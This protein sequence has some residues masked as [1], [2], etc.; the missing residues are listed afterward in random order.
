MAQG[1]DDL[2]GHSRLAGGAATANADDERLHLLAGNVV[3]R[4][5]ARRVERL[6]LSAQ[7]K[8]LHVVVEIHQKMIIKQ[9]SFID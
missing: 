4:R 2:V 3:P 6:L 7:N 9:C 8:V 1:L 5:T